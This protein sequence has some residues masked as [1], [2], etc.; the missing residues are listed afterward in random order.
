M[1]AFRRLEFEDACRGGLGDEQRLAAGFGM[2]LD[3]RMG[4][5]L[6]VQLAEFVVKAAPYSPSRATAW[7]TE[8]TAVSPSSMSRIGRDSAS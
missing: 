5:L 4:L 2:P 6:S 7:D 8:C 1:A 3:D